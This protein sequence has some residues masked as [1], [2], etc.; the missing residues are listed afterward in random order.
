MSIATL[1][2]AV[3][4]PIP[5]YGDTG[6]AQGSGN[7]TQQL[8][9]LASIATD[10]YLIG[11]V[12]SSTVAQSSAVS[13]SGTGQW[14][15]VTMITL[16]TGTWDISGVIGFAPPLTGAATLVAGG[17]GTSAHNTSVGLILGDTEFQQVPPVTGY[18]SSVVIPRVIVTVSGSVIYYL[19]SMM[20]FTA[21]TPTSYGRITAV[22]IGT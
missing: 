13:S 9:A 5:E 15:D 12:V 14:F 4:Y 20:F 16:T 17:I 8:V 2:G 6:W 3:S 21:A 7:L 11:T 18:D 1:I 19:K 22:Q 10:T